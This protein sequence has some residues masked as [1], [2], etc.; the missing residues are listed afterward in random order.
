MYPKKKTQNIV[1]MC[2]ISSI[3]YWTK[4]LHFARFVAGIPIFFFLLSVTRLKK[5][6]HVGLPTVVKGAIEFDFLT[7]PDFVITYWVGCTCRADELL[8]P[9]STLWKRWKWREYLSGPRCN[10]FKRRNSNLSQLIVR[11]FWLNPTLCGATIMESLS[12]FPWDISDTAEAIAENPLEKIPLLIKAFA[13]L[14][15][16]CNMS[17]ILCSLCVCRVTT[18]IDTCSRVDKPR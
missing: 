15:I 13:L 14:Y 10:F 18:K 6:P 17:S 7:S 2:I 16:G 9:S 1:A 3:F 5:N 4:D 8:G 11:G 12:A